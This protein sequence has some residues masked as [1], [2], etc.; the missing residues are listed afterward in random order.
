MSHKSKIESENEDRKLQ[1]RLAQLNAKLQVYLAS[2][3]GFLAG[4]IALLIFGYQFGFQN[5]PQVS[6]FQVIIAIASIVVSG[7]S[8]VGSIIFIY[9]LYGVSEDFGFGSK[10]VFSSD[11]PNKVVASNF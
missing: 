8:F 3:F 1:I 7:I 2:V 6:S 11:C 10:S 9:K 5:Y 4:G